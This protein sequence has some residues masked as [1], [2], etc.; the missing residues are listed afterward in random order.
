MEFWGI[1]WD[2]AA[3]VQIKC[4]LPEYRAYLYRVVKNLITPDITTHT[5]TSNVQNL[6]RQSPDIYWHAELFSKTVLSVARAALQ[7]YSVLTV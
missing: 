7:M 5:V 4:L 2:W 3:T 1:Y 6:S